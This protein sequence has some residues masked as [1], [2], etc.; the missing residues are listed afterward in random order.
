MRSIRS[1]STLGLSESVTRLQ[2]ALSA[3]GGGAGLRGPGED[4][5]GPQADQ[6]VEAEACP[7]GAVDG[8]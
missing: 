6:A 5:T 7:G 1:G 2:T 3:G 4:I 8:G